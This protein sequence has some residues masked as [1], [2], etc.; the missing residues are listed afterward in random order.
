MPKIDKMKM[1]RGQMRFIWNSLKPIKPA[2]NHLLEILR[3]LL[4]KSRSFIREFYL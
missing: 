2:V 4:I 3:I 1:N